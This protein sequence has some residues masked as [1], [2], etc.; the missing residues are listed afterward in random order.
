MEK[1]LT[2]G[3]L[4]RGG[5]FRLARSIASEESV[6]L[7]GEDGHPGCGTPP[8]RDPVGEGKYTKFEVRER[9]AFKAMTRAGTSAA[10]SVEASPLGAGMEALVNGFGLSAENQ[11]DRAWLWLHLAELWD[12]LIP[13]KSGK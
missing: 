5:I 9:Q 7:Y 12:Y 3:Q 13:V 4:S 1:L 2:G 8:W 6:A 11:R 10:S